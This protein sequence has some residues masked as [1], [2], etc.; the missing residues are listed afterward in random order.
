MPQLLLLVAIT[1][2][3]SSTGFL[4]L[5]V[6]AA[7]RFRRNV[8]KAAAATAALSPAEFPPV[9][10]LKTVCGLEPLLEENLESFFQQ[11]YPEF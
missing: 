10:I 1:G 2:L 9:S 4:L 3:V 8:R 6:L 5:V 11:D 7:R